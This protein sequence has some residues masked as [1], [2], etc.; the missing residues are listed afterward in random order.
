[1]TATVTGMTQVERSARTRQALLE[2]TIACL[3]EKG[4]AATSTTEIAQRAG[5]SRGAQLHHFGA[6]HELV[7][8]A[9]DHLSARRLAQVQN[10]AAAIPAGAGPRTAIAGLATTFSNPLYAATVELWIAARTDPQLREVLLPV[11]SRLL[12]HLTDICRRH[13]T[14]DPTLAVMTVEF[15]LGRGIAGLLLDSP[16]DERIRQDTLTA[17]ADMLVARIETIGDCGPAD[18]PDSQVSQEPDQNHTEHQ[19]DTEHQ[20][21]TEQGNGD[22]Q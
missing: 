18:R 21:H 7:V 2:A 10:A 12:A 9:V 11:E 20:N 5:V 6:K 8:A 13:I 15:L 22:P 16:L 1:M 17:F 3:M 4:Y 14:S 19:N